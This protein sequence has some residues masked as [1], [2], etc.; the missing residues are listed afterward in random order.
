M[1]EESERLD[2]VGSSSPFYG[3]SLSI[4]RLPK[5]QGRPDTLWVFGIDEVPL[6]D[7]CHIHVC[8]DSKSEFFS[9]ESLRRLKMVMTMQIINI[10]LVFT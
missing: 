10:Y 1:A 8:S 3:C 9:V 5:R 7:L 6:C 2:W 4:L